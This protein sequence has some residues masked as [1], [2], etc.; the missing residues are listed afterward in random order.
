MVFKTNET[1]KVAPSIGAAP[2]L[3]Q[4]MVSKWVLRWK[5]TGFVQ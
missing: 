5:E 2:G 3:S 4:E 1:S